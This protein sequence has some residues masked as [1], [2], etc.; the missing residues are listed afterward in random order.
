MSSVKKK[1]H[2]FRKRKTVNSLKK[3]LYK[4]SQKLVF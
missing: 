1:S 3:G 2:E 4:K